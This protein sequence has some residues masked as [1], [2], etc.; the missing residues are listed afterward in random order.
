M[1]DQLAHHQQECLVC[2]EWLVQESVVLPQP[3]RERSATFTD[4]WN[5]QGQ[6]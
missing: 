2:R 6:G 3:L 5:L 4:T 1:E